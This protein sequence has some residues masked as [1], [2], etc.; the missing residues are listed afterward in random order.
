MQTQLNNILQAAKEQ[1]ANAATLAEVNDVRVKYMGKKGEVTQILKGMGKLP[2]E[3]KKELGQAANKVRNEIEELINQKM[4]EVK[5][6]AKEA[7]FKAEKIDVTEPGKVVKA[8]VKHPVTLTIEEISKV[9]MN[10]GFSI[11]EGPEVETVF[12][13]FDG[14]NAGPNHPA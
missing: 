8:G 1:L 7:Q 14:L 12:Y 9:F 11:V 10:M 6:A 4:A 3:E 5:A 2:P 13:N